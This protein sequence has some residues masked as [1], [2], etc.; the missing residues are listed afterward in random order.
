M[1]HNTQCPAALHCPYRIELQDAPVSSL[2]TPAFLI[3]TWSHHQSWSCL[4]CKSSCSR[5][6]SPFNEQPLLIFHHFCSTDTA[7]RSERLSNLS[8]AQIARL[9]AGQRQGFQGAL[10]A[11]PCE[12]TRLAA[13]VKRCVPLPDDLQAIAQPSNRCSITASL[14]SCAGTSSPPLP[15]LACLVRPSSLAS[16]VLLN[17]S[18]KKSLLS[19]PTGG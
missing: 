16:L 7:A 9:R 5:V 3:T 1:Q 18:C 19:I 12:C 17:F 2:R 13:I 14:F 11:H 15:V 8:S 10:A 4:T 6:S